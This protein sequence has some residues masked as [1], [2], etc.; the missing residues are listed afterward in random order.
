MFSV[1]IVRATD[2]AAQPIFKRV[3]T[4]DFIVTTALILIQNFLLTCRQVKNST[5]L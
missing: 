4:K 1:S 2:A 5:L 3:K